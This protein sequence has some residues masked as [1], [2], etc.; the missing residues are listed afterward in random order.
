MKSKQV[1]FAKIGVLIALLALSGCMTGVK[2][3]E[4][5]SVINQR[6]VQRWDYLIAHQ[7]DK[8]YDFLSPG[9][10]ATKTRI[11]YATEMSARGVHWSK[12]HFGSQKCDKDVCHVHLVVDYSMRQGGPVGTVKTTGFVTE[13]WLKTDGKWYFL[14]DALSPTKLE[15]PKSS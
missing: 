13:T 4:D 2:K 1:Y 9:Y 12:V 8:A 15:K 3:D 10:R 7:G 11:A 6:A 14:P 5:A